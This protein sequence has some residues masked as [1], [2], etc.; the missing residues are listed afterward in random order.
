M[1]QPTILEEIGA[2]L[3]T[4]DRLSLAARRKINRK[5]GLDLRQVHGEV[6]SLPAWDRD[7][8]EGFD[9]LKCL[10]GPFKCDETSMPD[11]GRQR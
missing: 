7:P 5:N 8:H 1:A 2:D 3:R 11:K 4:Q 9:A 10:R 6:D